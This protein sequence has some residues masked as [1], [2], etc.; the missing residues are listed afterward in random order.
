[1]YNT[2]TKGGDN[3]AIEVNES[4]FND[5]VINSDKPVLVDFWAPW[6]GPCRMVAPVVEDISKEY[7]ERLKVV[8]VNVDENGGIANK[9]GIQN[10]PT[11]MLFKN[12]DVKEKIVGFKPKPALEKVIDK[13]M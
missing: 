7:S 1:M 13:L 2:K 10:I 6:C 9:Y 11:L 12:G 8:K 5:E 3:M 4:R